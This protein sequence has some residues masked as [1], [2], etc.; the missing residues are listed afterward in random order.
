MTAARPRRKCR[1]MRLKSPQGTNE[2]ST[3]RTAEKER[4]ERP[5]DQRSQPARSVGEIRARARASSSSRVTPTMESAIFPLINGQRFPVC[6]TVLPLIRSSPR[7]SVYL[8]S[9]PGIGD[10]VMG[11]SAA[12]GSRR[13]CPYRGP[14]TTAIHHPG[15]THKQ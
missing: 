14:A 8:R 12:A 7:E 3:T 11:L 5:R 9:C 13:F 1:P 15:L 2:Y 6:T 10:S 4:N